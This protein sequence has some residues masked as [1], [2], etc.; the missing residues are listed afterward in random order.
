MPVIFFYKCVGFFFRSS[1]NL[2]KN[3]LR[4]NGCSFPFPLVF[5]ESLLVQI[6]GKS[7][8]L[9]EKAVSSNLPTGLAKLITIVL[10]PGCTLE[11]PGA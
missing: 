10:K 2:S 11:S 3:H 9:K 4:A 5:R 1:N 7:V 8:S 6:K